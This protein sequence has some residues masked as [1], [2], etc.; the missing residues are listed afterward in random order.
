MLAN[1]L[2]TIASV[3]FRSCGKISSGPGDTFHKFIHLFNDC[4]LSYINIAYF[5]F[6]ISGGMFLGLDN[7]WLHS[8]L[9]WS[10]C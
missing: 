10:S 4:L 3:S 5:N 8:S 6:L 2:E 1:G 9:V 7:F